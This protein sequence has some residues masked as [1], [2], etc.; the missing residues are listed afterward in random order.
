VADP[1]CFMTMEEVTDDL[2][3]AFEPPLDEVQQRT[4]FLNLKQGK[5]LMRD[6]IQHAG[7]LVSCVARRVNAFC[8]PGVQR[9]NAPRRGVGSRRLEVQ[10]ASRLQ[11]L[12]LETPLRS[13][14]T[15]NN[16]CP[17]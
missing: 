13:D 7:H 5:L 10:K 3:L 15:K 14:S 6:Y 9:A 17:R 11:T 1:S 2:R 16:W 4:A 8:R 12:L